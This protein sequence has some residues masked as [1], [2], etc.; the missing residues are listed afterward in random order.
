MNSNWT[1]V[2][3]GSREEMLAQLGDIDRYL[4][5]D[6]ATFPI[7]IQR[8][9]LKVDLRVL[10]YGLERIPNGLWKIRGTVRGIK[11][12]FNF[13]GIYSP[14][15]RTGTIILN[16]TVCPSC[17]GSG[18]GK[19]SCMGCIGR[20]ETCNGTKLASLAVD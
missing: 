5:K 11:I 3:G 7:S 9:G 6:R 2:D 19:T 8:D 12:P 16:A 18:K 10:L 1:I 20:C 15:K 14:V 4:G 17:N 13:N